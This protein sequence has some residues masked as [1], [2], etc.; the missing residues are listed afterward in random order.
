MCKMVCH[1]V[2]IMCVIGCVDN[3][4]HGVDNIKASPRGASDQVRPNE[5][6]SV[7]SP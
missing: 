6:R 5:I 7:F 3:V 1:R 2:L 4:C